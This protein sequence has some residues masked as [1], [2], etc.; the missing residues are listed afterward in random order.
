MQKVSPNVD[1]LVQFR[2]DPVSPNVDLLV[3]F[4]SDPVLSA[5]RDLFSVLQLDTYT[6]PPPQQFS[7]SYRK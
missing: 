6:R 3:Q 7:K 5:V 4:R 1:L 2:S